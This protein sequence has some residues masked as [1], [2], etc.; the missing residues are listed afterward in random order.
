MKVEALYL[1]RDSLLTCRF[2]AN[3]PGDLGQEATPNPG[4]DPVSSPAPQDAVQGPSG[5]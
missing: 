4:L 3:L 2:S 1:R 5:V